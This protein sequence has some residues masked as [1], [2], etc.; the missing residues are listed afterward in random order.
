MG[1]FGMGIWGIAP[2]YAAERFPT[3]SRA[4][5]SGF[6]YNAAAALGALMPYLLGAFQDRAVGLASAMTASML[7][8]GAIAAALIWAGPETKGRQFTPTEAQGDSP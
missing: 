2:A 8:F 6:C 3:S 5:G 1:L 7:T 4:V